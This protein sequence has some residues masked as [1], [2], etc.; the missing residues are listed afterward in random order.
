M[1]R[2]D[3]WFRARSWLTDAALAAVL[4]AVFLPGSVQLINEAGLGAT[5]TP[6]LVGAVVVLHVAVAL[7]RWAT[8][9]VF[10][11][12][13]AAELVLALAPGL[14]DPAGEAISAILLPSSLGYLVVAYTVSAHTQRPWPTVSLV[15]GVVGAVLAAT[16]SAAATRDSLGSFLGQEAILLGPFLAAVVAAWA[17]GRFR[18]LR[19]DQ[20]AALAERARAAEAD[21]A[22]RDRRAAEE[23]R[24]RIARELHDVVSHSLSVM[25]R[26]AE[27]GRYVAAKDP[28]AA[29]SVLATVADTGREALTDMRALLGV[30]RAGEG[31]ESSTPQPTL[32]D[33]PELVE[34]VRR[35]GQQVRLTVEGDPRPLDRATH[36]AAYR[37][38]QEALTNVVKHA[39][40]DAGA[41]V[42]LAW[43]PG[44]LR[45][46]VSDTGA[47]RRT[48]GEQSGDGRGLLGMRER[49]QLAGGRLRAGPV[50]SGGFAVEAELPVP[51]EATR[52]TS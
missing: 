37:L 9:P 52:T 12:V 49:V 24:A 15:I 32:D 2:V 19:A 23:E 46:R 27:A 16:R 48:A 45:V 51:A 21:R 3:G 43:A 20:V 5:W 1:D 30:L 4:A 6:A 8:L 34:R 26:Q 42:V 25:V 11:V 36:L 38:V 7:R 10:A 44:A 50:G 40:P 28:A 14:A 22:Q 13:A 47:A 33:L 29:A 35:S 39:G 41:D 31:A 18:R 17:L